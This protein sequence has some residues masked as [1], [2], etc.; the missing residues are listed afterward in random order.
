MSANAK[1]LDALLAALTAAMAEE[2]RPSLIVLRSHIGYPAPHAI[3]TAKAHGAPL[4]DAEVRAT[5]ERMGFDPDATFVVDDDVRAEMAPVRERGAELQR[6]WEAA[7]RRVGGSLPR[8]SQRERELDLA[9][10]PREGWREALPVFPAG[11]DVA[12]RDAGK[13]VMQAL[14]LFTPTMVGGAADL[15]ESTKTEF[16]GAGVFCRRPRAAATSPSAS[17]STPWGRS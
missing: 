17:A 13:A 10:A 16:E 9:R 7:A 5:K 14:K 4:G 8:S 11:E 6:A 1:D 3:D 15:V 12:T 2:E